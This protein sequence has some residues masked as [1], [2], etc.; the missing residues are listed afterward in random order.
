SSQI[1]SG[2][3][4]EVRVCRLFLFVGVCFGNQEIGEAPIGVEAN[5][6]LG[7]GNKVRKRVDVVIEQTASSVIN[8]VFHAT[9]FD[10]GELHDAFDRG[11]NLARWLVGF[12]GESVLRRV[13]GAAGPTLEFLARSAL[14]DV[15]RAEIVGFARSAN[16]DGVEI[17]SAE[18]FYSG[19]NA[20]A[21]RETLLRECG[22]IHPKAEAI[23]SD[24]FLE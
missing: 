9:D 6:A 22:L 20:V 18:D 3:S 24:R 8:D 14:A 7:I 19:D 17:P 1:S 15:A 16:A 23:L 5:D 4:G 2:C 12:D 21:R 10:A 13:D 11:D